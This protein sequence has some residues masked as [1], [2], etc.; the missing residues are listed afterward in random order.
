MIPPESYEEL[1][2]RIRE[3]LNDYI[4]EP[5]GTGTVSAVLLENQERQRR[6]ISD[7][8]RDCCSGNPGARE[9]VK[10]LIFRFLQELEK[11]Q[12]N[13]VLRF[14][15]VDGETSENAVHR[16]ECL[17][18]LKERE[19]EGHGLE[20]LLRQY[21]LL[22]SGVVEDA[23]IH[24]IWEEE[25]PELSE[26]ERMEVLTQLLFADTLGLGR[27]D[28]FVY[29]EGGIEEIQ[30]GMNGLP[31]QRYDYREELREEARR[32]SKDSIHLL[33]EGKTLWLRCCAFPTEEEKQRVIRNLIKDSGAGELTR[34]NPKAV[35]E[36]ADGRRITVSRPPM[37]DAWVAL[38][39]KFDAAVRVKWTHFLR[40]EN[41]AMEELLCR[42][43][44]ERRS[45]AVTGEM[46]SGK[47]TLLRLC[48][49]HCRPGQ[50]MR[51]LE[52]GSFELHAREVMEQGNTMAMK[53]TEPFS[54]A[55]VLAFAR[56]TTG[57]IFVVGEVTSHEMAAVVMDISKIAVQILFSAHYC[58]TEQMIADFANA[59]LRHGG[60][61]DGRLAAEEAVRTLEI[62]IH[63]RNQE[64]IRFID[65]INE[66]LPDPDR[67]YRI[68]TVAR[69]C[70]ETGDYCFPASE[71]REGGKTN[72]LLLPPLPKGTGGQTA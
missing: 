22:E 27:I 4:R 39:R 17:V 68:R 62:E 61:T 14:L 52:S 7:C 50:S 56:K 43:L 16:L 11:N 71:D 67:G 3:M 19:Q 54:V 37:T 41:K 10:E 64:G 5:V 28:T 60:Y 59:L 69:Y 20:R 40:T 57:Q 42:L 72:A 29:Q 65:Y 36:T 38:I 53:V 8:I 18:F 51:I 9:T 58:S 23:V 32:F 70:T 25:Q 34:A 6:E 35:V 33:V 55:E 21:R 13:S 31:E 26:R 47:T 2:K 49:E 12:K 48:L 30:I 66:I 1:C 44:Q 46:A 24:K 15:S 63:L 45:I